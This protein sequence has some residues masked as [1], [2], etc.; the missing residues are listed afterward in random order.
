RPENPRLPRGRGW[1]GG[2]P[3]PGRPRDAFLEPRGDLRGRQPRGGGGLRMTDPI[4][5]RELLRRGAGAGA[6]FSFP[7]LL[8]ACGGGGGGGIEGQQANTE[9]ATTA[10]KQ[11]PPDPTTVSNWRYYIDQTD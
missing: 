6:L 1:G 9:A 3:R 2:G 7:A 8:A 4:T 10:V 11:E 5:R